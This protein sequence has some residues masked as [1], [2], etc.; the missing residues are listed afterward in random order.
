MFESCICVEIDE[1]VQLLSRRHPKARKVHRCDECGCTI[2]PGDTYERD[3]VVFDG[4]FEVKKICATCLRI[5]DSL[6]RCG[7]YYGQ[8]W[9]DIHEM[10]CDDGECICP[11]RSER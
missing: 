11:E 10:C 7:W 9:E 2:H 4:F 1:P 8:M 5:R 3:A 6:F